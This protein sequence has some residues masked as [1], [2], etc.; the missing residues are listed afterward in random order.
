MRRRIVFF[1]ILSF[2]STASG[3]AEFAES[4]NCISIFESQRSILTSS[5][6][7]SYAETSVS[8]ESVVATSVSPY[9]IP[10]EN[11]NVVQIQNEQT[12]TSIWA[13]S[14]KTLCKLCSRGT[15]NT[16]SLTANRE[17]QR[18]EIKG[19]LSAGSVREVQMQTQAFSL[20]YPGRDFSQ[21]SG[22]Q[23]SLDFNGSSQLEAQ[24][25]LVVHARRLKFGSKTEYEFFSYKAKT[26]KAIDSSVSKSGKAP[27]YVFDFDQLKLENNFNYSFADAVAEVEVIGFG[28]EIESKGK[29][30]LNAQ[31][32][33]VGDLYFVSDLA[34]LIARHDGYLQSLSHKDLVTEFLNET[35]FLASRELVGIIE[36]MRSKSEHDIQLT[37][38][39]V[40]ELS[41]SGNRYILEQF[42]IENKSLLNNLSEQELISFFHERPALVTGRA[43]R[44][45][46]EMLGSTYWKPTPHLL[47][48]IV[49]RLYD[50]SRQLNTI[51]I[52][53][54]KGPEYIIQALKISGFHQK[55][56][57][58][59]S[60]L[61]LWQEIAPYNK[62]THGRFGIVTDLG[63]FGQDHGE[64][65]HLLQLYTIIEGMSDQELNEFK[66]IFRQMQS[67]QIS[68][69]Y[70]WTLIFEAP[71]SATANSPRYWRDLV[72]RLREAYRP[73]H[74]Q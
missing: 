21:Y 5:V 70:L 23:I 59:V 25:S 66:S 63:G 49:A 45:R 16:L 48:T 9:L 3:S 35:I 11:M 6:G 68:F 53:N 72:R 36:L 37:P 61:S 10:S 4:L 20:K 41:Y 43:P 29:E 56:L 38:Q 1:G 34:K 51:R 54:E 33:I 12:N 60:F 47:R 17:K 52:L 57:G 74:L 7:Y 24:S 31:M 39:E 30:D 69:T 13:R 58:V 46:R 19:A 73:T 8:V 27:S 22:V 64:F 40:T 55:K 50:P 71:G 2:L 32:A 65:S 67:S 44:G 26:P 15:R 28:L 14:L 42:F 18:L 62:D